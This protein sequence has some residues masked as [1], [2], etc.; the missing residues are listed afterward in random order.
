LLWL[1]VDSTQLGKT[2]AQLKEGLKTLQNP[3]MS[4]SDLL[5]K[6]KLGVF[7]QSG[8]RLRDP[9]HRTDDIM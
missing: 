6:F 2:T 8:Y 3:H 1:H 4:E 5:D 9:E 7:G